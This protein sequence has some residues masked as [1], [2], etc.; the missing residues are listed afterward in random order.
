MGREKLMLN[1]FN[2]FGS[3]R[4]KTIIAALLLPLVSAAFVLAATPLDIAGYLGFSYGSTPGTK[5]TG[6]KPESKIWWN[7][8]YWWASLFDENQSQYYIFRL[9]MATQTWENTWVAIDDRPKSRAD[10]LWDESSNKLYIASHVHQENPSP[11]Q[12][13]N[14]WARLYRYT[15][16]PVGLTYTLDI[17]FPVTIN[18]DKTETLVLDK[19]SNGRLWITY[20]SRQAGSTDYHVY[21]NS[22][23]GN[24]LTWGTP[25]TLTTADS[26]V[27]LDDISSLISYTDNEGPEIGVMWS[28][29]VNDN[30]YFAT[31]PDGSMPQAGW[32]IVPISVMNYPS[33]D[34]INLAA[35]STGQVLAAIKLETTNPSD[36]LMGVIGR[37]SD[38]SFS[39]HTI[40]YVSNLETRPGV[41][42]NDS[43]DTVI[44]YATNKASGGYICYWTAV[45]TSPL[46]N[47]T[48][49][50]VPCGMNINPS[51]PILIGDNTYDRINNAS[52]TKQN[53]NNLSG[54]T[55]LASDDTNGFVYV[56]NVLYPSSPTPTN[57]PTNS[58]TE[59]N[60]P[61]PSS[62]P[63]ST[64][65]NTPTPTN[66]PTS[67]NTA[68]PT[69]TSSPTITPTSTSTNT[70]SSTP[71]NTA[72]PSA[73]PTNTTATPTSTS[74]VMPEITSTP[75]GQLNKIFLPVTLK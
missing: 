38:G 2:I 44:V 74:T 16:N 62:T 18:K 23:Q 60:T 51:A 65:T 42:I 11:V 46:S 54:L 68:T 36:P 19:D 71:G 70:P 30:F 3:S 73:T 40:T 32:T 35:T 20:V 6:E 72:S 34:H 52:S 8:G 66:T 57:T 48:F 45:L 37:D 17:G 7:S 12:N 26:R 13:S 25:F 67:T 61:T 49:P 64:S 15:F 14:D 1:K 31:H 75:G 47:M 53:I 58:P 27:D 55:V 10:V 43:N 59:T 24:D 33:D 22:S 39:F 4:K 63:A 21:I 50:Q 28:N 56:H 41:V 69:G 29:Q 9:N 5:I